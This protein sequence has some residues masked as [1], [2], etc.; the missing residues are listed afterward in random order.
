MSA[1]SFYPQID[2]RP[3]P[4]PNALEEQ[5]RAASLRQDA[6][7]TAQT[8]AQTQGLQQANQAQG[9]ALKDE[10]LRRQLA[11]Q[12]VQ[13][14]DN[15]KVTGF[16]ND[17][18]YNAMLQGGADPLSIQKMRMSQIELQKNILGL[19]S[20][21]IDN[22]DKTHGA[23]QNQL[24]TV[25]GV[26]DKESQENPPAAPAAPPAAV[27]QATPSPLQPPAPAPYDVTAPT[28]NIGAAAPGSPTSL[29]TPPVGTAP[30]G[31]EGAIQTAMA[32][33]PRPIGPKTQ[34][35]YQAALLNLAH[36]GIPIQGLPPTLQ[37]GRDIDLAEAEVGSLK[38][39]RLNAAELAKTAESQ[40]TAT[41]KQAEGEA[42]QWKPAGEGTL[43]NFKTGQVIHGVAPV[44][45]QE[46]QDW[47]KQNPGKGPADFLHYKSTLPIDTRYS[48]ES[49]GGV[50][51]NPTGGASNPAQVAKRFGMTQ[52]AFDQAAEKYYSTGQLP[53]V[54]RGISGIAL[55]RELMNRAG[56]LHPGASLAANSAEY[57][58]NQQSLGKLQTN[59]DQVT[60]FENTA[61][62]NLDLFLQTAKPVLDSGSPWINAP[63]RSVDA[64]ALG[65]A[66][67]AAFNAARQTAVTEIAKVLN[68]SNAS[69][70]LSDS[71][72]HEVEGLIGPNATLRQIA[73]AANVLRQDMGN[74]HQAYQQQIADIQNRMKTGNTIPPSAQGS[75]FFSQ[76]GGQVR[77]K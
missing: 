1:N 21:Q 54:G 72:R 35:A 11:P 58:A 51:G 73:S 57:K 42:S 3:T 6:A 68:S 77:P 22:W 5:Q 62:K 64:G 59:F 56:D 71:A 47:I 13:K 24:E 38:Q 43:V 36:Q 12:Y 8:Q 49:G 67:Q 75:D 15:G 55:N 52:E 76:Y 48:L 34:Q 65:S 40:A 41:Q 19:N 4:P 28:T 53:Q 70:V 46:M 20:A 66:E 26:Y 37:D 27:P 33:A 23:I 50:P 9:L 61:G 74:R 32:N 30:T 31:S 18:L 69:G 17:G 14:D 16:D 25:K 10:M 2:V 29:G 39:A 7:Q 60:A 63:L 45:Q 44:E